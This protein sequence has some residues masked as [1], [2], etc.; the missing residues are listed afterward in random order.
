MRADHSG[1]LEKELIATVCL[2]RLKIVAQVRVLKPQS[3]K[4]AEVPRNIRRVAECPPAWGIHVRSIVELKSRRPV[5]IQLQLAVT[6]AAIGLLA[7]T[8]SARFQN[9][10]VHLIWNLDVSREALAVGKELRP[11]RETLIN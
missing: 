9:S 6:I 4:F 5:L 3:V 11:P 7:L 2:V 1:P 8:H 10:R